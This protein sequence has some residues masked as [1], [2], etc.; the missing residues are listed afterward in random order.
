M[1]FDVIRSGLG[2]YFA[3]TNPNLPTPNSRQTPGTEIQVFE[4][5][6]LQSLQRYGLPWADILVAVPEREV[7]FSNVPTV[8]DKISPDRRINSVYISKFLAAAAAGLFDAALNYLWDETIAQLR[9]R[10]AQY[11]ISYFFDCAVGT[12]SDKRRRLNSSEDLDKID[13][14]ELINGAKQT[15]LISEMGFKHLDLIRYMRNWASAAHPNQNEL[16]GLQLVA[17]LQTCIIEVISTPMSMVAAD[18]RK[19]LS[20]IKNTVMNAADAK[21]TAA[22]FSNLHQEQVNNLATGLFGIYT[23]ADTNPQVRTNIHQVLP[24]LWPRIDEPT[25]NQFGVRYGKY[26]ANGDQDQKQ[27]AK[28]FLELVSGQSYIPD[29]LRAAELDTAIKNLISAHRSWSNFANEPPFA[30]QLHIL[31]GTAGSV[32]SHIRDKYVLSVIEVFLTNGNGVCIAGNEIYLKLISLFDSTQALISVLSF[33]NPQI[34]SKPQFVLPKKKY[35]ELLALL[36]PK[37][38]SPAV[39]EMID[40]IRSYKRPGDT[41]MEFGP[42]KS[43]VAALRAMIG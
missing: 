5:G 4:A 30:K 33:L 7:V 43:R 17:W 13:D 41:M 11:D 28:Q 6:L 16:T 1:M 34:A 2:T 3:M 31:V 37:F 26:V 24:L 32:P 23:R 22:F 35:L 19:F 9:H 39:I 15:E 40:H 25:R 10:V 27:L 18:I 42:I 20:N 8:I 29:D 38:T 36:Q 12:S 21:E 14:F